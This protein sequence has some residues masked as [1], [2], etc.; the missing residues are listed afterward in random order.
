MINRALPTTAVLLAAAPLSLSAFAGTEQL[1]DF[2]GLQNG[3]IVADGDTDRG[4]FPGVSISVDNFNS[5][6]DFAVIFDTTLSDTEDPDLEGP[7]WGGGNLPLNTVLGNALIIQEGTSKRTG[8]DGNVVFQPDDEGRRAAGELT[9]SFDQ[10][11]T[12][13]GFDLIDVEGPE[14]FGKDSGF[15]A[16]FIDGDQQVSVGFGSFVD[17]GSEFY[18]PGVAFGDNSANAIKPITAEQLGL[19]SFDEVVINLGGSSAVDNIRFTAVPSPTA[20]GAGLVA[21]IGLTARRRRRT[22]EEQAA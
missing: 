19:D 18:Q 16:T 1:I 7:S 17:P 20:A 12:S 2:E 5:S 6:T 9:F 11:I 10:E 13:F 15:F 21:L 22:A 8:N 3:L 14:E 4:F